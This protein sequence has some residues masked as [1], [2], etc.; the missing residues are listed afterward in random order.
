LQLSNNVTVGL[1]VRGDKSDPFSTELHIHGRVSARDRERLPEE[2]QREVRQE[3]PGHRVA[4]ENLLAIDVRSRDDRVAFS[5]SDPRIER[6]SDRKHHAEMRVHRDC[7]VRR[8]LLR[9]LV[10]N[11]LQKIIGCGEGAAG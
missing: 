5:P 9:K 2:S 8:T 1:E 7:S 4:S 11:E 10:E 6:L 3:D